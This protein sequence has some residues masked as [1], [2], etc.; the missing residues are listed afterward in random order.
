MSENERKHDSQTCCCCQS[1]KAI[2]IAIAFL[3]IGAF[4]G[5]TMTMHGRG[6]RPAMMGRQWCPM[7]MR[8]P[9]CCHM[10]R[11]PCEWKWEGSYGH[12]FR[13]GKEVCGKEKGWFERKADVRK[14]KPG[15]TCAKCTK[16]ASR[17]SELKKP[18]CPMKEKK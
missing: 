11:G 3:A 6:F 2:F 8:Q 16:K 1:W 14:C 7:S 18:S 12:K 17:P 13:E 10:M 5:H 15:C 4:L 9:C